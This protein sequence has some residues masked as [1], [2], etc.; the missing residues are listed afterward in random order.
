MDAAEFIREQI[1]KARKEARLSQGELAQLLNSTQS[2]ISDIERGRVQVNAA[3]LAHIAQIL[4]KPI[5][6]F[7]PPGAESETDLEDQILNLLRSVPKRWQ[8]WMLEEVEK[9]KK[10]WL[11]VQPYEQA[12]IPEEFYE[13]LVWDELRT[14]EMQEAAQNIDPSEADEGTPEWVTRYY[15]W[16]E[17]NPLKKE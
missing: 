9:F 10:V 5:A 16:R 3:D 4:G 13:F 1:R 15:R 7:Y 6:Y 14:M 11:R 2:S 8:K 12:G 17:D